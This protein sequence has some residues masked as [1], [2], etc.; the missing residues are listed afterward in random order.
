M[1]CINPTSISAS[2]NTVEIEFPILTLVLK[3]YII[4]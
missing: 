1:Q 3:E 2:R 4:I